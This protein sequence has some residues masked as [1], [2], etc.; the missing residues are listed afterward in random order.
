MHVAHLTTTMVSA[1]ADT[2]QD[3]HGKIHM[4]PVPRGEGLHVP[5]RIP[6]GALDVVVRRRPP[7]RHVLH[8]A[9]KGRAHDTRTT[10]GA[11]ESALC[12]RQGVQ[13][14]IGRLKQQNPCTSMN[15]C[16]NEA[17][18]LREEGGERFV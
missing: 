8:W 16:W 18:N 6:A 1:D 7:H 5:G 17:S 11:K 10:N 4:I 15:L 2:W 9:P 12:G 14:Q 13:P 3:T